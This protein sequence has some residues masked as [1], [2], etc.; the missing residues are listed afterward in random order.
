MDPIV[1]LEELKSGTKA[2]GGPFAMITLATKKLRLFAECW[3]YQ[4]NRLKFTMEQQIIVET[5]QFGLDLTMIK[6]VLDM[7]WTFKNA[8]PKIYGSKISDVNIAKM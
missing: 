1:E 3:D 5:V 2:F 6:G 4:L 7:N 8:R